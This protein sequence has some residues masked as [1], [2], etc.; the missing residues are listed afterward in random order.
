VSALS[1]LG[2]LR[3]RPVLRTAAAVVLAT[4]IAALAVPDFFSLRVAESL[5]SG[6]AVLGIA[7]LAATLALVAGGVDASIGALAALASL[8]FA[9]LVERAGLS[10]TLAVP[11]VIAGGAAIGLAQGALVHFFS[12]PPLL[13]TPVAALIELAVA[14]RLRSDAIAIRDPVWQHAST[15]GLDVGPLWIRATTL[16]WLAAAVIAALSSRTPFFER[17]R[18]LGRTPRANGDRAPAATRLLVF[19]LCS[20]LAALA[21]LVGA[22]DGPA[23]DLVHP[24][25]AYGLAI[26]ATA[27][28]LFGGVAWGGGR[29]GVL[30]PLLAV[31]LIGVIGF[32]LR[33]HGLFGMHARGFAADALLFVWILARWLSKRR[34]G[35]ERA[36]AGRTS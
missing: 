34:P 33:R 23:T 14:D 5:F 6:Q 13:M 2:L 20:A 12:S 3:E 19:S 11:A 31:L 35:V 30:G 9:S 7:T 28:A 1:S 16:A 17:V 25:L 24:P 29:G 26:E 32:V 27:A 36:T 22:L 10:V 4:T 8:V 21:G 18:A 15:G